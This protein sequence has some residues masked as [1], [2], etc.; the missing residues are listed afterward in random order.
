MSSQF[1]LAVFG[2]VVGVDDVEI[3]DNGGMG[4]GVVDG[5]IDGD[6]GLAAAVVADDEVDAFV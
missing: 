4:F 6:V 1:D 2:A 5:Q 3:A